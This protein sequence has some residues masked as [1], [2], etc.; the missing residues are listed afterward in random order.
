MKLIWVIVI[1]LLALLMDLSTVFCLGQHDQSKK[2]K[3]MQKKVIRTS[4]LRELISLS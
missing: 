3:A 4:Q 1:T 2:I